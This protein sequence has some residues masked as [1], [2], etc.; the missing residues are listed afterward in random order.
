MFR[1]ESEI[2]YGEREHEVT[3]KDSLLTGVSLAFLA[4]SSPMLRLDS[5]H[6]CTRTGAP[7]NE[8][9][10]FRFTC[11]GLVDSCYFIML[12]EGRVGNNIWD[13]FHFCFVIVIAWDQVVTRVPG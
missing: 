8:V 12:H 3:G 10:W 2:F 13:V 6:C 4:R 9:F 7:E 5:Q 1:S 11:L